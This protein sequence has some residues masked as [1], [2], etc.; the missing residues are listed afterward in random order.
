M[1]AAR[2]HGLAHALLPEG[3][4]PSYVSAGRGRPSPLE[5]DVAA[6]QAPADAAERASAAA[7]ELCRSTVLCGVA[8]HCGMQALLV[9]YG[10]DAR[11][12]TN[13]VQPHP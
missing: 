13:P 10:L 7:E 6:A 4:K 9:F 11:P 5:D 3:S 12:E 1:A 8:A 2:E